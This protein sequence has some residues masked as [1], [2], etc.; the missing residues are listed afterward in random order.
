MK[1]MQAGK[2]VKEVRNDAEG[3]AMSMESYNDARSVNDRQVR[4]WRKADST[5]IGHP[6]NDAA[7]P[8]F[9]AR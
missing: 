2:F 4:M 8:L 7:K 6:E 5:E 9:A 3:I 1:E